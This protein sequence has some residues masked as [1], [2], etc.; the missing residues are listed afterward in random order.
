MYGIGVK[1]VYGIPPPILKNGKLNPKTGSFV[2]S[3]RAR[4]ETKIVKSDFFIDTVGLR[5]NNLLIFY[6]SSPSG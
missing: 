6:K 2:F 1:I 4:K 5:I 3:V